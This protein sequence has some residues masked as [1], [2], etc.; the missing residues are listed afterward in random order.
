MMLEKEEAELVVLTGT[1]GTNLKSALEAKGWQ[2]ILPPSGGDVTCLMPDGNDPDSPWAIKEV[3]LAADYA[4]DKEEIAALGKGY[5]TPT[6]QL[7]NPKLDFY[8]SSLTRSYDPEKAKQLLADAGYPNGF[9]TTLYF[10]PST[11]T[12]FVVA[13]QSNLSDVGIRC[14][15]QTVA[16]NNAFEMIMK[17]WHNGCFGIPFGLRPNFMEGVQRYLD[18][19][20]IMFVSILNTPELQEYIDSGLRARTAEEQSELNAQVVKYIFDNELIIPVY[21]INS[22]GVIAP[23]VHGVDFISTILWAPEKAWLSK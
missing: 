14:E 13:V 22:I 5:W 7:A 10:D 9:D 12:D 21:R 6:W 2:L 3:R 17:G 19:H 18:I 15:I 20:R 23:Y 8:D 11:P 1:A 4:L 16:I